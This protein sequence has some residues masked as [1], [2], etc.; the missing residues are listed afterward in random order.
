[1]AIELKKCE[2]LQ[3]AIGAISTFITEGNFRFNKH[4]ISF[5][6]IDPSQ[7]VLVSYFIEKKCFDKFDIEPNFIGIDLVELNKIMQRVLPNDRL[8][9]DVTD[10]ELLVKLDG[11]LARAFHLPLLDV[12][13]EEINMPQTKF[14]ATIQLNARTIKEA[15]KDASLFGSSVVLRAKN[16]ELVIEARGSQG[17][18]KTV[19]KESKNVSIKAGAEVVSKYSL[20]FLQN[21][22]KEADSEKKILVEMKSDAPMRVSYPIG[23]GQIV[24]HL[25]HM[26]L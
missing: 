11:E 12:A 14:D 2:Q 24:Y 1:M 5:K 22:V 15:L 25:A 19:I 9:L 3:K 18:L 26:I 16:N 23:E 10:S 7:I 13:E 8:S 17:N 4:G 20:N 6:A 21:L